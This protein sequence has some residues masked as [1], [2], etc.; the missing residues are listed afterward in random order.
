VIGSVAV[1]IL[2]LQGT[3]NH[4]TTIKDKLIAIFSMTFFIYVL[5]FILI[6]LKKFFQIKFT[7][8]SNYSLNV[9]DFKTTVFPMD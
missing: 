5:N 8:Q 6:S 3:S 4:K 2:I 1:F 7:Y 9:T